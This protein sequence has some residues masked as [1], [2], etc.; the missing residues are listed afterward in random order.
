MKCYK[1]KKQAQV[2]Y[3]NGALCAS[4]FL[5]ILYKRAKKEL[6]KE[7]P[8]TKGEKVIV[9]GSLTR[10]FL[11]QAI[12]DLPLE[13]HKDT[14]KFTKNVFNEK[15]TKYDKIVIPWTANDEAELFYEEIIKKEANFRKIGHNNKFVKIFKTITDDELI[16]AS[17]ILNINFHP[18]PKNKE[19]A[20]IRKKYKMADFG[21]VKSSEEI[22]KA[23][24]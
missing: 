14:R 21:L 12:E 13:I 5:D 19:I 20:L 10:R 15:F 7:C 8:F 11:E 24:Q 2:R 22:K 3:Q 17:K 23:L 4:C 16:Q 9:Y 6:R 18:L 1:C